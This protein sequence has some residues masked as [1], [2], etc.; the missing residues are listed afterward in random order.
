[1][2][3]I[4]LDDTIFYDVRDKDLNIDNPTLDLEVNKVGTLKFKIYPSHPLFSLIENKVSKFTVKKGNRTIFKGRMVNEEQGINKSK[5]IEAE[6][7]L[8]YLNDSIVRPYDFNGTPAEHFTN[9]ITNHNSQVAD[10]QKFQIGT[11]TVTDP[12]DYIVRS[13]ISYANTWKVLSEDLLNKLGGYLRIRYEDDGTYIDYLADF[14]DTSTQVIELGQNLI[15]VLVKNNSAEV[16]SVVIPLGAEQAEVKDEEG[17]VVTP[18]ERLTIKSVNNDLDYLVNEEAL[19]KYG[20]IVAPI[21]DTTFEDVTIAS[22]LMTKGQKYLDNQAV[23]LKSTLE[24]SA[25]DL[26]LTDSEIE[27]FFI[28]EYIRFISKVHNINERYVS[29][30]ISIP[31]KEPKNMKITL[32]EERSSLTGI[33][34]GNGNKVDNLVNRIESVEANYVINADVTSIVNTAIT[35][36]TSILQDAETIIMT[37]LEDYVTTNDFGTFQETVTNQFIQT[38]EDFTF[39]FNNLVTQITTVEGETQQQFQEINKYIRFVDGTI[40]LGETGNELTLV[41]QN[42]RISFMQNNSEVAYFSNNEL[43]VTDARF[44][45]SLRIGNFAW[46]PRA[47]GNLSLV[48]VGGDSIGE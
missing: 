12:N 39:N 19:N 21:E 1:M 28:Y 26:N 37:A 43:T 14:D 24:V 4:L 27:A 31:I 23:M 5:N 38:A 46:K 18:K 29:T 35:N 6:G 36:N 32:G 2:Y 45:N 48:Y 30:K 25:I 7:S 9:L 15:D 44:L 17:N 11:I 3:Q 40:V 42:D 20:W 16:Y 47:N 13:S 41:Q 8:A 34:M 10:Y 22:N 33:Q